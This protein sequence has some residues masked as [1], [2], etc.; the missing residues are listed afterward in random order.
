[1]IRTRSQTRHQLLEEPLRLIELALCLH[2][3]HCL[4]CECEAYFHNISQLCSPKELRRYQF[5]EGVLSTGL[6]LN[7]RLQARS[8]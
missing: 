6:D 7:R 3:I 2:I 1:M 5:A 4:H 8:F